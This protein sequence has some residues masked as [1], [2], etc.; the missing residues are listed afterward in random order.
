MKCCRCKASG[1]LYKLKLLKMTATTILK[2]WPSYF[3]NLIVL[4]IIHFIKLLLITFFKVYFKQNET[5]FVKESSNSR[6]LPCRLIVP[7]CY[8]W[9]VISFLLFGRVV[10]YSIINKQLNKLITLNPSKD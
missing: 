7:G 10:M 4:V 9:A 6:K 1:L 8:I 3:L 5:K 2:W